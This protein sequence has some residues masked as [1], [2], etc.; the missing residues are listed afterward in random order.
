M[1][2]VAAAAVAVAVVAVMAARSV[3][4][5]VESRLPPFHCPSMRQHWP[6]PQKEQSPA[7]PLQ[8]SEQSTPPFRSPQ[9]VGPGVVG[10]EVGRA[11][12]R[13]VGTA[14]GFE[15]GSGDGKLEGAGV[16]CGEGSKVGSAVRVGV[17]FGVGLLVGARTGA[18]V[19]EQY[20]APVQP[21]K[22][23]DSDWPHQSEPT[24]QVPLQLP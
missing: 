20:A 15:L 9:T 23:L 22:Q 16:G 1:A 24:V 4:D 19:G 7:L 12:G 13:A 11:V 10:I 2:V 14:V 3:G 8:E 6:V 5:R 21:L 18:G 17:G